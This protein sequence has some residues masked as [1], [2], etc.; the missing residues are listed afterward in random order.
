MIPPF[1]TGDPLS[2]LLHG[3]PPTPLISTA[4]ATDPN[5]HAYGLLYTTKLSSS[6]DLVMLSIC[7]SYLAIRTM[8]T[9]FSFLLSWLQCVFLCIGVIIF[10]LLV[11]D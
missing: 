7:Q 6:E 1:L 11:Q 3:R 2:I 4:F 9:T 5:P 10:F 8:I